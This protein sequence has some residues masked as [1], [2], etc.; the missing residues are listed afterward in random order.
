[1]HSNPSPKF[2]TTLTSK[3]LKGWRMKLLYSFSMLELLQVGKPYFFSQYLSIFHVWT[4]SITNH[5]MLPY[6]FM[7]FKFLIDG[8]HLHVVIIKTRSSFR[9]FRQRLGYAS[10][11]LQS[12]TD[13]KFHERSPSSKS[14]EILMKSINPVLSIRPSRGHQLHWRAAHPTYHLPNSN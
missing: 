10:G 5:H 7:G 6:F 13:H 3:S 9:V 4:K 11:G 2:E 12:D 14:D 1:M 8:S